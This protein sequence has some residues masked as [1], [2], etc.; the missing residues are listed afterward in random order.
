MKPSFLFSLIPVDRIQEGFVL[1]VFLRLAPAPADF[2]F[3][4]P[5]VDDG[6][7]VRPGQFVVFSSNFKS[8]H[9]PGRRDSLI[10]VISNALYDMRIQRSNICLVGGEDRRSSRRGLLPALRIFRGTFR[11]TFTCTFICTYCCTFI[12]SLIYTFICS[13]TFI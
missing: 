4:F 7:A 3:S 2:P 6:F 13:Y 11:D 12:S 8:F 10:Q 9:Q 5:A 1:P